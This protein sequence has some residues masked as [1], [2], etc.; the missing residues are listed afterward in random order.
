M[1]NKSGSK[2]ISEIIKTAIT[3]AAKTATPPAMFEKT[4]DGYVIIKEPL[5]IGQ[6]E[7]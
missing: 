7:R 4:P 5:G 2:K 3:K 6:R 1:T